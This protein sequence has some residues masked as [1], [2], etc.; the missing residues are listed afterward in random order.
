MVFSPSEK[1]IDD[2]NYLPNTLILDKS[3]LKMPCIVY[4]HAMYIDQLFELIMDFDHRF[5]VITHNSDRNINFSP[6]TNVIKYYSQNVNVFHIKIESIPIGISNDRWFPWMD[7]KKVMMEK[8]QQPRNYR[9]L[10]Y[11]NFDVRTNPAKRQPVYDLFKD[12]QWVT[13]RMGVNT[14]D[15]EDYIDN[16]YNHRFVLCP[17]GNGIDTHR[18]WETLYLGSIPIVQDN[19]NNSFYGDLPISCVGNWS[20]ITEE[21]LNDEYSYISSQKWNMNKL[22]FSYWKHKIT[23]A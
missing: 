10:V 22:N 9:N 7:R 20:G 2:Y 4:T 17:V 19:I 12:K 8:L 5:I 23:G 15:F 1:H 13:T 11:M 6:P 16:I 21:W 14:V 18:M 3:V